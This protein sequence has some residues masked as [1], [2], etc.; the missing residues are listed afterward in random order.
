MQKTFQRHKP[1]EICKYREL[2]FLNSK[3]KNHHKSFFAPGV[4]P[5]SKLLTSGFVP[6]QYKY[7]AF[8]FD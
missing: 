7:F 2:W 8:I 3:P 6:S 1:T 5:R 4:K